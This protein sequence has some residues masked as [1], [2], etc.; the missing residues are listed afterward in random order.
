MRTLALLTLCV[1]VATLRTL[2]APVFK[3]S[4]RAVDRFEFVEVTLTRDTVPAGNPFIDAELTGGLL[5]PAD[6]APRKVDGFCDSDDGRVFRI[7]F[8]PQV[9][10]RHTYRLTF[11][12]G[13]TELN[14]TGEFNARRGRHPGMVR[15]DLRHPQH[16]SWTGTR[17]ADGSGRDFFLYNSTTA[18]FL[19]G[20]Q[21]ESVIRAAID[22]LHRLDV[23]RIRVALSGRNPGGM[24]WREPMITNTAEFQFRLEPW[25]AARPLEIDNPGYDIS[26]FNLAHFRKIERMLTHARTHDL[27][28]SLIFGV[29]VAD[30]G[31]DPFGKAGMGGPDEQRYYRYC[32]ARFGA[33]AN[34]WWD[35]V[36]EW[37]LCR[38][39]AWVN[40][41][42]AL[43]KDWDPY[44]H[45]T[46]VHGTGKFPFA[47]SPWV[48]YVMFQSWDEHGAY[49]FL[50]KARN[51]LIAAQRPLPVINEE[52]GYED[53]YPYPWG[54]KRVW[55][56]RIAEDRVRLAWEMMMAGGYQTTGERA[57]VAGM[58]GWI[59][60]RGNDEMG[61]LPGYARMRRFF[62][63]V[64]WYKLQPRPDLVTG[65]SQ[66]LPVIEKGNP[67][68]PALCLN[69]A[70]TFVIYLRGGGTAT[71]KLPP[72]AG[73]L[74]ARR[75]NPRTGEFV[76]L[77]SVRGGAEW[78]TPPVPDTQ[79]WAFSLQPAHP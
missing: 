41:M 47:Q 53:H 61:M 8:M 39:E 55:P 17:A 23:N 43:V 10:G 12:Q 78:T 7:R 5:A 30:K 20:F 71:V 49:E 74:R 58:G 21:D 57:N 46:S 70:T 31:V 42:G 36:N 26:R 28:V 13:A 40:S 15:R 34:V 32:V 1:A 76:E 38:D 11:R 9:E 35:I 25:P 56:A 18:Y 65:Q 16:F 67:A 62:E 77:P 79:P 59:N 69:D 75:F 33:F 6:S 27:Q 45:T 50:L 72:D 29:D 44:D 48:D 24:R 19:L 52:Y 14:H 63:S 66:A 4:A 3:Q 22:R 51:D 60:G 68:V 73:A 54:G 37:H 2:A 64:P